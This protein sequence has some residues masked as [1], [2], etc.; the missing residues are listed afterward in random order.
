MNTD[1]VATRSPRARRLPILLLAAF[2]LS[3]CS[4][5][6]AVSW[7][8]ASF[9]LPSGWEVLEQ[10]PSRLVLAD[11]LRIDGERGVLVTF[12]RAAGT[13]PN[14]WRRSVA[15]RGATLE[16]DS[17]VLIA[18]DVPA[19]QLILLDV[20]DGIPLRE[21]LLVVPSRGL[22]I[23]ITPRLEPG[24]EDGP[25]VLLASLDGVREFL[26]GVQLSAPPSR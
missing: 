20:V 26:D 18:G 6:S 25:D 16:T 4:G 9:E 8:G 22:V 21:A 14:E 15:E 13:L 3:A 2:L 1:V 11:H 12:V 19:T 5:S 7:P 10:T 17:P 24:D 23:A